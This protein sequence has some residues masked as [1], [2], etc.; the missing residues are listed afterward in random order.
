LCAHRVNFLTD[1]NDDESRKK[2]D[3]DLMEK[4]YDEEEV[5]KEIKNEAKHLDSTPAKKPK[6][7][8]QI[9]TSTLG[10]NTPQ[11]SLIPIAS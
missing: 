1:N 5:S 2:R 6:P 8:Q 3:F 9:T 4:A 10:V 7:T 11:H